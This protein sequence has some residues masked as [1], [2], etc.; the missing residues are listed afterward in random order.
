MNM[1][2]RR[3]VLRTMAFSASTL[4]VGCVGHAAAQDTFLLG[5]IGASLQGAAG[6]S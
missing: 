3:R 5:R 4:A 2:S 1:M 6:N